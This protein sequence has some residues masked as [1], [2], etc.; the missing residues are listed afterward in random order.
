MGGQRNK[1]KRTSEAPRRRRESS[2][3]PNAS[4]TRTTKSNAVAAPTPSAA[5][6]D[7][8]NSN[9]NP[10][11]ATDTAGSGN[12]H[13]E[14]AAAAATGPQQALSSV[15]NAASSSSIPQ[16]P[17]ARKMLAAS[18]ENSTE[19]KPQQQSPSTS[20]PLSQAVLQALLTHR[21][22][23]L[24]RMQ[25]A[26]KAARKRITTLPENKDELA[27]FQEM[28]QT[29][30][31]QA[32]KQQLAEKQNTEPE[33]RKSLSLRQ[34]TP[35]PRWSTG[36]A[37]VPNK[38]MSSSVPTTTSSSVPKKK[39]PS[40]PKSQQSQA[41][42]PPSSK[43]LSAKHQSMSSM[44]STSWSLPQ[45]P[46]R[47]PPRSLCPE[48]AALRERQAI[49][50]RKL[51]KSSSLINKPISQLMLPP[52]RATHWDT[53]LQE[54]TWLA[55]DVRNERIWKQSMGRMLS[56]CVAQ[57][58]NET[59]SEK[60]EDA[61]TVPMEIENETEAETAVESQPQK[62]EADVEEDKE[63]GGTTESSEATTTAAT[64]EGTPLLLQQEDAAAE[65]TSESERYPPFDA[66]LLQPIARQLS[67]KV[68]Q[69]Y[70]SKLDDQETKASS[71]PAETAAVIPPV[72]IDRVTFGTA[73]LARFESIEKHQQQ[74][75]PEDTDTIGTLTL[76]E[77][78]ATAL[79][80]V[81]SWWQESVAAGVVLK[82]T[83][84]CGKTIAA[85]AA[86]WR[87][88]SSGWLLVICSSASLVRCVC[89]FYFFS[90]FPMDY[91]Y[92]L[93]LL[94]PFSCSRYGGIM[95]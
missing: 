73:V 81:S 79:S 13:A 24:Q 53:L 84:A 31:V 65:S 47:P 69:E 27:Q 74:S 44:I 28:L 58:Q 34:R 88:R 30:Q 20:S 67:E 45:V 63:K 48:T 32:K 1:R 80:Q 11:T 33:P 12:D 5:K 49:L 82:G 18:G 9:S 10:I 83:L 54:M 89:C 7:E 37:A 72:P 50:Q 22:F 87:Q 68:V 93:T 6:A 64:T 14:P 8:N 60:S 57:Q 38:T 85:C 35:G 2:H 15:A 51:K 75:T 46:Q 42:R 77:K 43:S 70:A 16:S 55:T 25:L 91:E 4:T 61:G 86:L 94:A 66:S 26:N 90:I 23:L 59:E 29:V 39:A 76:S 56:S 52:R 17:S 62:T 21:R 19:G 41:L 92:G 36:N 95:N 71:K 78:Q 3:E 40:A